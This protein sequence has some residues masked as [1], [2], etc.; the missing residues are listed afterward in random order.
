MENAIKPVRAAT[1]E[2]QCVLPLSLTPI[3]KP[4]RPAHIR[5]EAMS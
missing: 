1:K 5:N 3:V 2:T 4:Q